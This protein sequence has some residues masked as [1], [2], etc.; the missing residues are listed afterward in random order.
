[1]NVAEGILI[2]LFGFILSLIVFLSVT[3]QGYSNEEEIATGCY[4]VGIELEDCDDLLRNIG[5]VD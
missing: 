2:F 5:L 3:S 1:M 4:Q